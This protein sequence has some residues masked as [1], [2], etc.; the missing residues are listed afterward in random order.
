M[1]LLKG[2]GQ[3]SKPK[4]KLK[5]VQTLKKGDL[6]YISDRINYKHTANLITE[7]TRGK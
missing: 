1:Q 6:R 3:T 4:G 5:L 7:L 2:D